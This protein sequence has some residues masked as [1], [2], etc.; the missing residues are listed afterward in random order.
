MSNRRPRGLELE[1]EKPPP[2]P[3]LHWKRKRWSVLVLVTARWSR[4]QLAE[5]PV[6]SWPTVT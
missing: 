2:H 5:Y 4:C 6:L 3:Y 1:S